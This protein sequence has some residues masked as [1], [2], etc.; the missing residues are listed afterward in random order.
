MKHQC[1]ARGSSAVQEKGNYLMNRFAL[2]LTATTALSLLTGAAVGAN[3]S[4]PDCIASP[5]EQDL[6]DI[7]SRMFNLMPEDQQQK[8]ALAG[9][10]GSEG[11]DLEA[12][13]NGAQ[14]DLSEQIDAGITA[15]EYL[16]LLV[17]DQLASRLTQEQWNILNTIA[18]TLD[19]GKTVPHLCFAPGTDPE[20][21]YAINQLIEFPFQV[22]FQQTSRWNRTATDGSG[23][24]QGEPTTITYSF[25]PDGTFIPNL[26][27]GL[28]SG[29][30][31]LFQWLNAR[32]GSPS[33]WQPLFHQVFDR[34][35]ELTGLS[36]V[37]ETND[38]GS[39][40]NT[41][42][43]LLGIRGD[44]RIGAFNFSNDGN[45]GVLAY[46]NFPNDG[47]M[48]FD[49]F[50][51]YYNS[52]SNNSRG[53]RNVIAHEHGHGLGMLHVCPI[54]QTKL[55]EPFATNSFDG[56][57]LDDILNGHRHY[58]DPTE[59]NNSP[60]QAIDMGMIDATDFYGLSNL[61]IDDNSD[62]DMFV[63]ELT[64]R[65]NFRFVIGA[66]AGEYRTGPQTQSCNNGTLVDYNSIQDLKIDLYE[67]GNLI[68]PIA[69]QNTAPAGVNEDLQLDL[70]T[71][72]IYYII[73]SAASNVNNVQRYQ[74]TA[75]TQELPPIECPA[76][77]TGD[78]TL[79]FFDVSAF[80][81]AFNS[82]DP[83]ADFN[84][85]GVFNFFDVSAFL[86]EFNSGCP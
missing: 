44:V 46:N 19:S 14:I 10:I 38:D 83:V 26:G 76:D 7:A 68:V 55:M 67:E 69:S 78:G 24:Q 74:V 66:Q 79:D 4:Y 20:Y 75:L 50:D 57:Q 47:D 1:G 16:D 27:L 32:Y 61:S 70:E 8:I 3:H 41:G 62:F 35:G 45:F 23:L 52:T 43:G 5:H 29:N 82:M 42:V 15:H 17:S 48:I 2:T 54:N 85:D 64:E 40:T 25:V 71:P 11:F 49:A 28:G 77:I 86:N 51:T 12:F 37:H 59:P 18:D 21:A 9:G 33:T 6:N 22:R 13:E 34:W 56:P 65:A 31:V 53:L 39:N 36:Y 63:F 81:T 73:I 80:L 84:N 30:S 58:G 60:A 72:G